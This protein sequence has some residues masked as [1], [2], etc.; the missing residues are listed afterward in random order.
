MNSLNQEI[1]ALIIE[2]LDLEDVSASDIDD[3]APLFSEYD[4]GLGLDSIDALEFGLAVKKKFGVK[5]DANAAETK[6][7]FYS[8][9]SLADFILANEDR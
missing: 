7:H 6:A 2:S 3:S 5:L 8:V 1:K 4:N 9:N